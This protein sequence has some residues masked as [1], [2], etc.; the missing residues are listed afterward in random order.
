MPL[1]ASPSTNRGGGPYADGGESGLIKWEGKRLR[2]E[3]RPVRGRGQGLLGRPWMVNLPA[4]RVGLVGRKGYP[5]L[6]VRVTLGWSPG[7]R[8][9]SG[10]SILGNAG[11]PLERGRSPALRQRV[12]L[13]DE[14]AL[15]LRKWTGFGKIFE[16]R[17]QR[18]R[19]GGAEQ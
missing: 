10:W 17:D 14:C 19:R 11:D 7:K 2:L 18:R 1:R 3:T 6:P 15:Q 4:S 13:S 9:A 5:T 16:C 8:R 12:Q